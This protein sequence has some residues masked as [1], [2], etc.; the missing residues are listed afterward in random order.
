[1]EIKWSHAR[2]AGAKGWK[3]FSLH[4]P[5]YHGPQRGLPAIPVAAGKKGVKRPPA[6]ME[7][8]AA[9][10]KLFGYHMIQVWDI[11]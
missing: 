3:N 10:D 4:P 6:P 9:G 5:F 2:I 11:A 8:H 7:V 1:M